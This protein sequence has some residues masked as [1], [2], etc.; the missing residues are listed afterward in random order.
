[1]RVQSKSNLA[2]SQNGK[3]DVRIYELPA[4]GAT[5]R[6]TKTENKE[7]DKLRIV[8]TAPKGA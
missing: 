2:S 6:W 7:L 3:K 1:M 8:L 5:A 4:S